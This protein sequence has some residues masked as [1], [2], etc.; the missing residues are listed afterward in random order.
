MPLQVLPTESQDAATPVGS[1]LTPIWGLTLPKLRKFFEEKVGERPY[2]ATQ[3]FQWLYRQ[4]VD[5]IGAMSNLGK[6][7]KTA[8]EQNFAF[9][10]PNIHTRLISVDGTRKYLFQVD[11][12]DL[13]ESVMIKQ[14]NRMTLCV[15]SQVGCALG[16]RF[17]K[18]G[19]M[20]L[21]R[22]L[23]THEIIGQ[24]MAVIRDAVNFD[25]M[26]TN[27]VFMGMGEPL[28]NYDNVTDALRILRDPEGLN[29]SARKITISSAG[30]AP[31]LERFGKETD[32]DASLA[33]SLN[34][35][36][37]EVR[38]KIM[39]I[40]KKYPLEVLLQTLKN[41]PLGKR[42]QITMEYVM[43]GGVTDT[44]EDLK[45]L[46]KLLRGLKAKVN[47]IPYNFNSGLGFD[48]PEEGLPQ[49]WQVELNKQGIIATIRWSKGQD[50]SAACG[51][52]VTDSKRKPLE[53]KGTVGDS[54]D[55]VTS[56]EAGSPA[57]IKTAVLLSL[58]NQMEIPNL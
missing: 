30:L 54:A 13:V 19:T 46:P 6:D 33:I 22:N 16:C 40:N 57:P 51:Q 12:G 8:L 48:S 29:M 7:V 31:A 2:R 4:R 9:E 37:D 38:S 53:R 5:S 50:I 24:V 56:E 10:L 45:R 11:G 41:Y 58:Q 23:G 32:V 18:T 52:L 26:F 34:A 25:D 15:S 28:H 47:L 42:E 44:P 27:I 1:T 20:G 14:P 49:K 36:T 21:K 55:S 39:P 17:C 43:L 35:T 3:V